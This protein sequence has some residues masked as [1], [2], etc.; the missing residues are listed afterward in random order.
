MVTEALTRY[1]YF[2]DPLL[3]SLRMSIGF[4]NTFFTSNSHFKNHSDETGSHLNFKSIAA[5]AFACL[6]MLFA[7]V[8]CNKTKDFENLELLTG[9]GLAPCSLVKIN[10]DRSQRQL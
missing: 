7:L 10:G 4:A 6:T 8:A 1:L 3:S 9:K 5:Q 2:I